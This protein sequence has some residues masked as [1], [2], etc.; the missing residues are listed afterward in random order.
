M[1][2][3]REYKVGDAMKIYTLFSSHTHYKRDAPFWVWINRLISDDRSIIVV[4]EVDGVIV[5]HYAIVPRV[6]KLSAEVELRCGLGIHAFVAPDYRKMVTIFSITKLAYKI[7]SL[8]GYDFIYGFPNPNFRL[9]QEKIEGWT[10]ISTFNA[11]VKQLKIPDNTQLLLEWELVHPNNFDQYFLINELLE[12]SDKKAIHFTKT[13]P[14]II[15]RYVN[16]PQKLYQNWLLSKD[17]KLVGLIVTKKIFYDKKRVHIID[18]LL[19]DDS[20]LSDMLVDFETKFSSNS[21]VAILWPDSK[22][23]SDLIIKKGYEQIGFD[24]FFGVKILSQKAIAIRE[25]L[26]KFSNWS[27]NMGDSDAF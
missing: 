14:Y 26:T 12:I 5:G 15:N 1:V 23:F 4:A 17:G 22:E 21:D 2:N 24:T 20:Y 27:L 18:Y 16:H 13:L 10:Q 9:L 7:A 11:F 3:I 25:E 8:K 6:C 19:K